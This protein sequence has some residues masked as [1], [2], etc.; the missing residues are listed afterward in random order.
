MNRTTLLAALTL[1]AIVA[2]TSPVLATRDPGPGPGPASS[3]GMAL[4][5][6][7]PKAPTPPRVGQAG[8]NNQYAD[9][10]NLYQYVA[11]NPVRY[12][13]FSGLKITHYDCCSARQKK[14]IKDAHDKVEKR[15]EVI[16]A[17]VQKYTYTWVINNYVLEKGRTTLG[18]KAQKLAW[19]RYYWDM[20]RNIR[21]MQEKIKS[22]IGTECESEKTSWS[23]DNSGVWFILEW[24][25][26][27]I[28]FYGDYFTKEN[29]GS[30][31]RTFMHELSHLA[32]DTEDR[33]MKWSTA[34]GILFG[35]GG[36]YPR[37]AADDADWFGYLQIGDV[38]GGHE[39]F[40]WDRIWPED[41]K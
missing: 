13:D 37:L 10:M 28:H 8:L 6:Y 31:A 34:P 16:R 5:N 1:T 33:G 22:G 29:P 36:W 27:D 9:G 19:E 18:T 38:Y 23:G 3:S 26:G 32:A 40:I 4:Y 20:T 7:G 41:K 39:S 21:L 17:A 12:H 35:V 24:A 14:M 11:S 25:V 2:T 15:L 30:Q